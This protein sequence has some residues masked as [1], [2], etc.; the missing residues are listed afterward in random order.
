M[1]ILGSGNRIAKIIL[2]NGLTALDNPYK[3]VLHD[4][5]AHLDHKFNI[6]QNQAHRP[7][8]ILDTENCSRCIF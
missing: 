6:Y 2:R 3:V 1:A 5:H 8:A 7:T 4:S